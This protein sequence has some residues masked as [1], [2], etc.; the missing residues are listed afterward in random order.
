M[1]RCLSDRALLRLHVGD[2]TAT[3]RAHRSECASCAGR[4]AALGRD[5]DRMS[6]VL[7]ETPEPRSRQ[8][9]RAPS[10]WVPMIGAVAVAAAAVLWV[11]TGGRP[12][13]TPG[14]VTGQPPE[15]ASL[16]QDVSTV[17]FSVSG[18]PDRA[19]LDLAGDDGLPDALESGCD[20]ANDWAGLTC[21]G[22]PESS[23]PDL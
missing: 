19:R 3:E 11:T 9:R 10:A 2:G 12:L 23:V 14:P 8:V 13:M 17:M 20:L 5:V 18:D 22:S 16:L 6:Q 1:R 21:G 15:L 4:A 7:S